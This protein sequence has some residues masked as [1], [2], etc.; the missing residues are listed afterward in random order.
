MV[1]RELFG[2]EL[3]KFAKA[4][5]PD[6]QSSRRIS[7]TAGPLARRLGNGAVEYFPTLLL[8]DARGTRS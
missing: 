6:L 8:W 3:S 5:D 7:V 4:D 2:D 1:R